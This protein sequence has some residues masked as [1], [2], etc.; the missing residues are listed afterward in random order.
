MVTILELWLPILLSGVAVFFLSFLMWMVFPHHRSDWAP[1]PDEDGTMGF[2]G[3]IE[4]GQYTFPHCASPESM[5]DPAWIKKA[6][7]GP[8]GLLI[9]RPRGPMNMGKAMGVSF[10]FNLCVSLLTA[11]IFS[12]GT[13]KIAS[14]MHV[15]RMAATIAFMGYS[16]AL[17]WNAVWWSQSWSSTLKSMFDGL[18]YGIAT[19][20]L[21]MLMWPG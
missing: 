13:P 9:I 7:D 16:G 19:G 10:T 12:I 8:S 15:F 3:D 11:Y 18:I 6:E 2:L 4:A 17:V 5:K 21:F 20:L 14:D 1:L